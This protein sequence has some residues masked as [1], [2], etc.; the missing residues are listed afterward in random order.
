MQK[1]RVKEEKTHSMDIE[2]FDGITGENFQS[3]VTK[4]D[5]IE[6]RYNNL[7]DEIFQIKNNSE[8]TTAQC[9]QMSTAVARRVYQLFPTTSDKKY[10]HTAFKRCYSEMQRYHGVIMVWADLILLHL[11]VCIRR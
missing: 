1:S 9:V 2:F 5:D 7:R 6:T 10:R 11:N 4:V 8:I 3:V